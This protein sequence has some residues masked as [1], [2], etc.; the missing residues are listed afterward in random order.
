MAAGLFSLVAEYNQT[1]AADFTKKRGR[2]NSQSTLVVHTN[3]HC[4][5]V[6]SSWINQRGAIWD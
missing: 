2:A 1:T 6:L 3:P 5:T 4:N